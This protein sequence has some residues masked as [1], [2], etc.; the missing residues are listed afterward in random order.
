M[1]AIGV[2][3]D[4]AFERSE[5]EKAVD[6][7]KMHF[8][9]LREAIENNTLKQGLTRIE[10]SSLYGQPKK[11]ASSVEASIK[12]TLIF[13]E[14]FKYFGAKKIYLYFDKDDKLLTWEIK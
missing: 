7:D 2:L 4:L 12:E 10:V 1:E 14:P 6:T 13:I 5:Q 8:N 9:A 3:K 11:V